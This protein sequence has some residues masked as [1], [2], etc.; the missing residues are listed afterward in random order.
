MTAQESPDLINGYDVSIIRPQMR[1]GDVTFRGQQMSPERLGRIKKALLTLHTLETMATNIYRF[2]LSG[3]SNEL[4][5]QLIAAMCNEMT[6]K[7]DFEVKLH[8]FGWVP[9]KLRWVYWLVGLVLGLSSRL[10]GR[11]AVLRIGIWT[12]TKAVNHY[13]QLLSS[14]EWDEATREIVEKDQADEHGHIN[15]WQEML[16]TLRPSPSQQ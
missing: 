10:R 12:E 2:Q 11:D 1:I 3:E 6:H 5:R 9:S 16:N 13:A 15:R 7:Q 8:E 14:V 4:N